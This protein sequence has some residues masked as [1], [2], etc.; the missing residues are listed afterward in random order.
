MRLTNKQQD[1]RGASLTGYGLIVGL[2]AIT[3]LAATQNIGSSTNQLFETV[4]GEMEGVITSSGASSSSATSS[5]EATPVADC[6]IARQSCQSHLEAG[7]TAD[8]PYTVDPDGGSASNAHTLMCDMTAD[9]GGWTLV[10]KENSADDL[11]NNTTGAQGNT[12]S[13]LSN[14][15]DNCDAKLSDSD[16][17]LLIGSS[18]D[19]IAYRVDSPD[20]ANQYYF[21][22]MCTYAHT[23]ADRPECQ[24]YT[25]TYTSSATPTYIQCIHW[26]GGGGGLNAW[27]GCGGSSA[28]GY[29]NV[30]VTTRTDGY[31][32]QSGITTNA[33]GSTSG[34]SGT[35]YNNSVYFWVR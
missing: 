10:F 20:I 14:L 25:A 9:D 24:K 22:A 6:G 7:C 11:L 19:S 1:K 32:D 15:T 12:A 27:Y 16:I 5:P 29:T 13:C 17:N 33:S 28:F 34:S 23:G 31:N 26:G 4:G 3:A 35:S 8:G 30:A 21:S 2:I 18:G